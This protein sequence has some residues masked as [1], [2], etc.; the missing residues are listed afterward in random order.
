MTVATAARQALIHTR[1]RAELSIS[2][3]PEVETAVQH[4]V[5][6]PASSFESIDQALGEAMR[7]TDARADNAER[8]AA[9]R[10]EALS[11]L[12]RRMRDLE[13]I[14]SSCAPIASGSMHA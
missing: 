3:L 10:I 4:I 11:D 6:Q 8:M 7:L 5:G 12:D 2:I 1:R 9:L 14:P 13:Q